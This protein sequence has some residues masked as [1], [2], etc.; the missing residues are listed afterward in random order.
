MEFLEIGLAING[1][2]NWKVYG[3]DLSG[4]YGGLQGLGGLEV[5]IGSDGVTRGIVNDWWGNTVGHV[6]APGA[7]MTWSPAQFLAWGP[8]PGWS[9]PPIDGTKPLH[10]LLGYRGLT[11]DPPGYVQQGLSPYDPQTGRWLSPDPVGH[12]GSLSLYDYCDNDPLNVFDPDGRFGKGVSSGWSGSIAANA[13]NSSA[14][15]AGMIFGG[16]T[17]GGVEGFGIGV[18]NVSGYTS[19]QSH[20]TMF[21]GDRYA[22]A[23]AAWNPA[24]MAM[25]GFTEAGGGTGMQPHNLGQS[26]STGQ[27]V[28]SGVEGGLGTVGTVGAGFSTAALTRSVGLTGPA[29]QTV[30]TP[31]AIPQPTGQF[32]STAFETRLSPTSYLGV[33]RGRHFQE[34]NENFLRAMEGDA[35]LAQAMQQGGVN[36]Q[37]TA[38]GLAPRTP[39]TGWTWHHAPETG[40]MQLVPRAQHAPGSIFQGTLHPGGQG[41]YSI[42]GQ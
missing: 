18:Q 26:L 37:R 32:Y 42:W 40:V 33:S 9:T 24:Y 1:A 14:F 22:A 6:A 35:G 15:S 21:E 41:G 2:W 4:A 19:Y 20:L 38:T 7:A 28:W 27:R 23:N 12:V 10:E 5:V 16:G 17:R 36:L 13:P 25:R 39:P 34:A 11:L 31:K 30:V 29:V 8:A 3:P